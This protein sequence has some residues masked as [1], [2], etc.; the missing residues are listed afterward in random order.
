MK[1]A[2]I[3]GA[4]GTLGRLITINFLKNFDKL[5]LVSRS[6]DKLNQ[7]KSE[8][9][10]IYKTTIVECRAISF[11]RENLNKLT[12]LFKKD[13]SRLEQITIINTLAKQNP[14]GVIWDNDLVEWYNTLDVNLTFNVA[15]IQTAI[16]FAIA[17]K[18]QTSIILFSGGGAAYARPCFSAYGI[19]KTAVLRLVENTYQEL[20]LNQYSGLIQI[21]AIAPGSVKSQLTSEIIKAGKEVVGESAFI[22]AQTTMLQGGVE[23]EKVIKLVEFLSDRQRN[24]G[25]SGRLIHVNED[26]INYAK[27]ANEI[28]NSAQGLLRRV[29]YSCQKD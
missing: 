22:E 8:C 21:N 12:E 27:L 6:I 13:F 5:V 11:Q 4:T 1:I 9:A 7:L 20:S 24:Q 25:I 29:N 28:N 10:I 2:Y 23:P 19:S 16:R 14:L 18:I 15:L 26:Y 17:N 3:F